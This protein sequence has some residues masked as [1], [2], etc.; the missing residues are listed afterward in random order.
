MLPTPY[1]P[2]PSTT[3]QWYVRNLPWFCSALTCCQKAPITAERLIDY[4]RR[5]LDVDE[6]DMFTEEEANEFV[7]KANNASEAIQSRMVPGEEPPRGLPS[8]VI[9]H[10]R[11]KIAL[12]C[13]RRE[14]AILRCD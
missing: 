6:A 11:L 13:Y 1:T 14:I 2:P 8:T 9:R 10:S 12:I 5:V 4:S 3:S 7:S